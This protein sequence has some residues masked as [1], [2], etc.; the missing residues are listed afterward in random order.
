MSDITMTYGS[1][2]SF[3]PVPFVSIT[4]N[5]D[6]RGD[7][8]IIGTSFTMDMRGTLTHLGSGIDSGGGHSLSGI[9]QKQEDL[10]TAFSREGQPLKIHCG[11]DL[12]LNCNPR[13]NSIVFSDSSNNWVQT[14]P[15]TMQLQFDDTP[16]SSGEFD[17]AP[18]R[19]ISSAS[20]TWDVEPVDGPFYHTWNL[21]EANADTLPYTYRISHNVSA[22]GKRHYTDNGDLDLQPWEEAKAYVAARLGW[23]GDRVAST[24]ILGLDLGKVD[25][26]NHMRG[27][28]IDETAGSFSVNESWLAVA[29]GE[30]GVAGDAL[31]DFNISVS[32]DLQ[33]GLHQFNI[34][35]SIQG[36]E[37]RDYGT[38]SGDFSI[39]TTKLESASGYFSEVQTKMYARIQN[40]AET[41][42][43]VTASKVNPE[44]LSRTISWAPSQGSISYSYAYDDRP[45]NL[46]KEASYEN[47]TID[48]SHPADV[49]ATLTVLGRSRGPILQSLG[50]VTPGSRTVNIEAQV[51]PPTQCN[52]G[53]FTHVSGIIAARPD[54][55]A[56]LCNLERDLTDSYNQVYKSS[57]SESW[58]PKTGV[59]NRTITWTYVNCAGDAPAT[60]FATYCD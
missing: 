24:G 38:G 40:V 29:T 8:A 17:G 12:L 48:D 10:R 26:Y 32:K 1:G 49:F 35:G 59:F 58:N 18:E 9:L 51:V 13:V 60:S 4:K 23:N 47:I 53:N 16:T 31:E 45:C 14:C 11:D 30:A 15:F 34:D 39:S 6:R 27:E 33:A 37:K 21:D 46:I 2:Y 56:F 5:F 54:I 7:G 43:G 22:V 3:V 57:D 41:M 55:N 50:T 42:S 25:Y 28:N 52:S 44:P 19:W 36:L 20:E